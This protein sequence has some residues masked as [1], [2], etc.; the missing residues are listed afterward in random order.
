MMRF[1]YRIFLPGDEV[2]IRREWKIIARCD[3]KVVRFTDRSLAFM[4]EVG[5][6]GLIQ[7]AI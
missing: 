6:I 7:Q 1:E 2:K 3:E 4:S 5:D